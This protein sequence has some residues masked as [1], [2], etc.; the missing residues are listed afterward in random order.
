MWQHLLQNNF[1][2]VLTTVL[3]TQRRFQMCDFP[4]P[5]DHCGSD[6]ATT[7]T[8]NY[9]VTRDCKKIKTFFCKKT[10]FSQIVEKSENAVKDQFLHS[11]LELDVYLMIRANA[12]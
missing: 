12:F 3:Y 4:K 2:S 6:A 5:M 8:I 9:S 7:T 10:P 11:E 1:L